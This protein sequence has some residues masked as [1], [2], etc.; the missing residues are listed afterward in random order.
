MK[1]STHP[2]SSVA[3]KIRNICDCPPQNESEV[4]SSCL[5][6]ERKMGVGGIRYQFQDFGKMLKSSLSFP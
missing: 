3:R 6:L 1:L 2:E 4:P 5:E